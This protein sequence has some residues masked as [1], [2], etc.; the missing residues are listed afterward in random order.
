MNK[1][2]YILVWVLICI[3]QYSHTYADYKRDAIYVERKDQLGMVCEEYS[4]LLRDYLPFSYHAYESGFFVRLQHYDNGLWL[5]KQR[6]IKVDTIDFSVD[7]FETEVEKRVYP[8]YDWS[9]LY[10]GLDWALLRRWRQPTLW[11]QVILDKWHYIEST[12][13]FENRLLIIFSGDK[14]YYLEGKTSMEKGEFFDNKDMLTKKYS[15]IFES[16][17]SYNKEEQVSLFQRSY[18]QDIFSLNA[19]AK[20]Y[21]L[22]EQEKYKNWYVYNFYVDK[23]LSPN[24]YKVRAVNWWALYYD[25]EKDVLWIDA[26][27]DFSY[28]RCYNSSYKSKKKDDEYAKLLYK[29][30]LYEIEWDPWKQYIVSWDRKYWPYQLISDVSFTETG[31]SMRYINTVQSWSITHETGIEVRKIFYKDGEIFKEEAKKVWADWS[32]RKSYVQKINPFIKKKSTQALIKILNKIGS[33]DLE[34]KKYKK[35]RDIIFLIKELIAVELEYRY[36]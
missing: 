20:V 17:S 23:I 29:K 6:V 3:V 16:I 25:W 19:W 10:H 5:W 36:K 31:E 14:G 33:L 21:T 27:W 28:T 11:T 7:E 24:Q 1:I 22:K 12:H 26:S 35:Y 9:V 13:R 32:L 2:I 8:L 34:Q 18:K 30:Y 4:I 15:S